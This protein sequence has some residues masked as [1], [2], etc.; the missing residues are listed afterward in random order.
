LEAGYPKGDE[1]EALWNFLIQPDNK[2]VMITTKLNR[3]QTDPRH[4]AYAYFLGLPTEPLDEKKFVAPI[5][6]RPEDA[7]SAAWHFVSRPNGR[8]ALQ[9]MAT[10]RYLSVDPE[11]KQISTCFWNRCGS[12]GEADF[13]LYPMMSLPVD[14]RSLAPYNPDIDGNY[15]RDE[16]PFGSVALANGTISAAL[17]R[18]AL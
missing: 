9:H 16:P 3:H 14:G 2:T 4:T 17:P 8:V 6:M 1:P 18:L 11:T 7:L 12:A 5:Q 13:N 15:S 10:L